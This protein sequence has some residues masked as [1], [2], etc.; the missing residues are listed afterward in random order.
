MPY[1]YLDKR[2]LEKKARRPRPFPASCGRAGSFPRCVNSVRLVR[3]ICRGTCSWRWPGR[4][5]RDAH[6]FVAFDALEHSLEPREPPDEYDRPWLA[7]ISGPSAKP[8][9]NPG[10]MSQRAGRMRVPLPFGLAFQGL[11]DALNQ[12]LIRRREH[13]AHR[14]VGLSVAIMQHLLDLDRRD[15]GGAGEVPAGAIV[16]HRHS[17]DVEAL[18]FHHPKNLLD[19]PAAPIE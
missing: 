16:A 5:L 11:A 3:A 6:M 2:D 4:A 13:I 17:L 1:R 9:A 14:P 15:Q 19:A 12:R 10:G 8:G 18:G 7:A